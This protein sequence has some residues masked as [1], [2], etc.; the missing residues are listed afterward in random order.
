MYHHPVFSLGFRAFFF[1]AGLFAAAAIILWGG[2][3]AGHLQLPQSTLPP[4]YWHAHEMVYGYS[5]AV[6]AGFLLTAVRNWTGIETLSGAPLMIL[7][8]L[9]LLARVS[10]FTGNLYMASTL[11]LMFIFYLFFAVSLPIFETQQWRQ[12]AIL[13]KLLMMAL[14]NVLFYLGAFG[15]LEAGIYLGIYGGLY[16]ILGLVLMMARRLLPFFMEAA[17]KKTGQSLTVKNFKVL[18]IA[19]LFLFLGFFIWELGRFSASVS[20]Y[21]AL[22]M[23]VVNMIRLV[24]WFHPILFQQSLLWVLYL[25][26][27]FISIGFVLFYFSVFG[28]VPVSAA[29]HGMAYGGIGVV[30]LGMMARVALGHTGRNVYQPPAILGVLF[31]LISL[32]C[33]YTGIFPSGYACQLQPMD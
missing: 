23:G 18:D 4:N 2:F 22:A 21:L 8:A 26:S 7:A 10:L 15:V 3:F 12:L 32:G 19:S 1:L 9:W 28:N 33:R 27:W 25:A 5:L 30:T 17:A 6:V 14:F 24:I 31:A 20:A 13:A 11:D 16:L 29:I